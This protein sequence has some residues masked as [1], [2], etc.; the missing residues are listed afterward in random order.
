M[1]AKPPEQRKRV[2]VDSDRR[3]NQR[4]S[5]NED[6]SDPKKYGP[7]TGIKLDSA[8]GG[9]ARSGRSGGGGHK[10]EQEKQLGMSLESLAYQQDSDDDKAAPAAPEGSVRRRDLVQGNGNKPKSQVGIDG[11]VYAFLEAPDDEEEESPQ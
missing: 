5:D 4:K 8:A 3:G 2:V 6:R 7:V 9:S 10:R 1:G 11:K